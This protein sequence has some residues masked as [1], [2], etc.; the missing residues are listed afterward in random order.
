M[1]KLPWGV[2]EP[3]GLGVSRNLKGRMGGPL[4]AISKQVYSKR[5]VVVLSKNNSVRSYAEDF[6]TASM[7]QSGWQASENEYGKA[8]KMMDVRACIMQ[9][10]LPHERLFR[11]GMIKALLWNLNSGSICGYLHDIIYITCFVQVTSIIS[12]KFWYLY[13]V[14]PGFAAYQLFG[15]VKGFLP[16]GSDGAEEDEKT[17]KK[18]EKMGR[19]ASRTK[20][21]KTRT[22]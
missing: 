2:S 21:V 17:R 3:Q 11:N 18:R 13:L 15:L 7:W 4:H 9:F 8:L 19:K 1:G 5:C 12:E 22:R 16:H 6:G 20:M 10:C 14:I